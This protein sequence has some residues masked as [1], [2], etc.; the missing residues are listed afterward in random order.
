MI[1]QFVLLC[2]IMMAFASD[3]TT[4]EFT[5]EK[6]S[7]VEVSALTKA[8]ERLGKA[9][10]EVQ[11]ANAALNKEKA[12]V[13]EV[14]EDVIRAHGF[15]RMNSSASVCMMSP[16]EDKEVSY[17]DVEIRGGYL[18][19]TTGKTVCSGSIALTPANGWSGT[20]VNINDGDY[21]YAPMPIDSDGSCSNVD[22][23]APVKPKS[24]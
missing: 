11:R 12:A 1:K 24:N 20:W 2:V 23:Q 16:F 4:E 10:A 19:I 13:S 8:R 6:L 17:S 15:D 7:P 9:I 5:V 22:D 18:L 21:F 14:E 3:A